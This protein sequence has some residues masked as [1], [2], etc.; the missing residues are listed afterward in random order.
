VSS[1]YG[2]GG[3]TWIF[4]EEDLVP[5]H[6]EQQP[7]VSVRVC[8]YGI[9][10]D[11]ESVQL[12]ILP[13]NWMMPFIPLAQ[14][15]MPIHLPPALVLIS[16]NRKRKQQNINFIPPKFL[17]LICPFHYKISVTATISSA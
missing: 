16:T 4:I 7:A 13:S 15:A 6:E 10:Y 14:L 9:S 12:L 17:L 3:Y 5:T 11:I 1:N 8:F 2:T